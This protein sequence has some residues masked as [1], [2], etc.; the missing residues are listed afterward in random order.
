MIKHKSSLPSHLIFSLLL[1]LFVTGCSTLAVQSQANEPSKDGGAISSA[2]RQSEHLGPKV[3]HAVGAHSYDT[4]VNPKNTHL[5]QP[6]GGVKPVLVSSSATAPGSIE[7]QSSFETPGGSSRVSDAGAAVVPVRPHVEDRQA[8]STAP[9]TIRL[10]QAPSYAPLSAS[11]PPSDMSEEDQIAEALANPLS[12]LWLMFTQNDTI[13]YDGDIA[14]AL[15]EDAK[16]QNTLLIQPVLSFQLTKNWKTIIRP[17]IP[18]NSFETVGNVDISTTTPGG[19][20]GVDFERKTGLGDIVLWTAFSNQYTPPLVWGFGPT[21]M[22]NTSTHDQLGT[23]KFSAGP[24]ALGVSIT[25]KWILGGVA[26]Y[27]RS[28]AGEDTITVNTS[29][30]DVEAN[31]PDVSLTD[32]QPIIRYRVDNKTNIGLAPNWRY[33]WETGQLS[34]PLGIGGDTLIKMGRLPVKIGLEAYYYAVRDDDFG[35]IAQFRFLFVPVL[36]APEWSRTPIF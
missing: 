2:L 21:L 9:P 1:L 22:L 30:G 15:G 12:Y 8:A 19:V 25:E 6:T 23:G 24:M 28:F 32:F 4:G 5:G 14:D 31:R 7:R 17:V 16:V 27:W 11:A 26:Q 35:P 18:I 10:S 29:L 3:D 20:T 13:W 33:N 34:L 36:P